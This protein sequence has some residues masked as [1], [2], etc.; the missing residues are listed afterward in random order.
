[1]PMM[2][3]QVKRRCRQRLSGLVALTYM[4]VGSSLLPWSHL[5]AQSDLNTVNTDT[6]DFAPGHVR[7]QRYT[8]P[9][10]CV[11]A[12]RHTR[13]ALRR[14]LAA[15]AGVDTLQYLPEQDTL[16]REV[17]SVARTC[18][19]HFTV[20]GTVEQDLPWLFEL[21]LLEDNDTL[22][23]SVVARRIALAHTDTVR[24][25]IS[26][27]AIAGYLR[28][29][30]ARVA[31]ADTVIAQLDRNEPHA[32]VARL[33]AHLLAL[34]FD[35]KTYARASMH[36]EIDYIRTLIPRLT[37]TDF[38]ARFRPDSNDVFP[39]ADGLEYVWNMWLGLAYLYTPDS[40]S[41]IARQIQQ[42]YLQP[43]LQRYL[44]EVQQGTI[45]N[46]GSGVPATIVD[47]SLTTVIRKF[48]PITVS[49]NGGA[50]TA[51]GAPRPGDLAPQ[52]HAAYWF[53]AAKG[54]TVQPARGHI[55]LILNSISMSC[56]YAQTELMSFE[57]DKCD[58]RQVARLR[59]YLWQY[60]N[61]G[62][63]VTVVSP[64]NADAMS[65][66]ERPP[67]SSPIVAAT[68]A[69]YVRETLHL[70]V[71]VAID[72]LPL[73]IQLPEPDGRKFYHHFSAFSQQYNSRYYQENLYDRDKTYVVLI[74]RDGKILYLGKDLTDPLLDALLKRE[75]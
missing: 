64:I 30:P 23:R 74:G 72:T 67:A 9:L 48:L 57:D 75:F 70:P 50:R 42:I 3:Y 58:R 35:S 61:A 46:V 2:S 27:W 53:V 69:R 4:L 55:S 68:V 38:A 37:V 25:R 45:P 17:A 5:H 43:P 29:E 71:T 40:L 24:W 54:D 60:G 21:A 49:N 12:A 44:K 28:A 14:S 13:Q 51:N 73:W 36:R 7:F 33:D 59:Y 56:L 8:D 32:L 16:P 11:V 34:A 47:S 18:G 62:L 39:V 41:M 63:A 66:L 22:A 26:L 19:G 65:V 31:A 6:G 52:L 1:M 15:R 10:W 20:A